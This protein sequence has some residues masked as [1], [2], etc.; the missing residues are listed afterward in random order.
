[1]TKHYDAKQHSVSELKGA[2]HMCQRLPYMSKLRQANLSHCIN[3]QYS[4]L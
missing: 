2:D 1:M 3:I 4:L